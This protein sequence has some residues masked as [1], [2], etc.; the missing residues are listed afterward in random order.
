MLKRRSTFVLIA[1]TVALAGGYGGYWFWG[2]SRMDQT[3]A[4][5]I[6]GWRASGYTVLYAE[7]TV[8]GFPGP[9]RI[10]LREPV[11]ADPSDSWSWS[12]DGL[13]LEA[14]PW[15]PTRYRLIADGRHRANLPIAGRKVALVATAAKAEGTA[16]FDLQGNLR[17]AEIVLESVDGEAPA[18]GAVASA[19][20]MTAIL[21][22]AAVPARTHDDQQAAMEL[23][24]QDL[25]LPDTLVNPLGRELE[26]ISARAKLLGPL[27][28]TDLRSALEGWRDS[29]GTLD[30]PWLQIDW[31]PLRLRGE[32]TAAL[33]DTL[34]PIAAVQ[35][36][37]AGF[38]ETLDALASQGLIAQDAARLAGLALRLLAR[39]PQNGG[40]PELTVPI[41]VQ[42]GGFYLGPVKLGTVPPVLP[43]DETIGSVPSTGRVESRPLP[44]R[45]DRD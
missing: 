23:L 35:T 39:R 10:R 5:W 7:K 19:G 34:R 21:T 12:A 29:G 28:R 25:V 24:F 36:R 30:L 4:Q 16:N 9:V 20:R 37:I 13:V 45:A 42:E 22:Q 31:G 27:R 3:V 26:H 14:A 43:P 17:D 18:L 44:Q 38:T 40:R 32:G 6:D 2:A 33:D 1:V 41:S 15:T 11:I 8:T